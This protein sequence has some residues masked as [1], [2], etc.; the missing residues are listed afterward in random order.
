MLGEIEF[1][2]FPERVSEEPT[3]ESMRE[4]VSSKDPPD[5]IFQQD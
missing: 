4:E 5:D 3:K 1:K 2:M